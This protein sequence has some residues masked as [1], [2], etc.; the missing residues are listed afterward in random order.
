MET[1]RKEVQAFVQVTE[2]LLSPVYLGEALNEDERD[3]VAMCVQNL[4]EKYP[5]SMAKLRG[6]NDRTKPASHVS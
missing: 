4:A 3:L 1:I 2:K 5:V 6:A